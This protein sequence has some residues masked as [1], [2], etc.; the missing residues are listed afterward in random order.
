MS[1][2]EELEGRLAKDPQSKVFAQLAEEYRKVGLLEDAINTCREGLRVH[3][4]YFSARVAL[5]RALLETDS[6]HEAA[7]EFERVL[8]QVPDNIL[9]NKFLGETYHKLGRL[10]EAIA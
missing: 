4:N 10:A 7:T 3:P 2:I 1:R 6:L 9:A 8:A 5:G